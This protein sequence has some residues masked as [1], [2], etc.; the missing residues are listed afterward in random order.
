VISNAYHQTLRRAKKSFVLWGTGSSRF[1]FS[2]T[3]S[4]VCW[5]IFSSLAAPFFVAFSAGIDAPAIH[6][7]F[8]RD[9]SF[10]LSG[11]RS[12]G[13]VPLV[14]HQE[15]AKQILKGLQPFKTPQISLSGF[16]LLGKVPLVDH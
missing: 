5:K 9:F 14:D 6:L 8:V 3:F 1:S 10:S 16:K 2:R 12:L 13:K 4:A 11:F 15:S 7:K